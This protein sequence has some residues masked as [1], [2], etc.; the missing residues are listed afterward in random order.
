M[1]SARQGGVV[2]LLLSAA[3]GLLLV[4]GA[5]GG[6]V[7]PLVRGLSEDLEG[8]PAEDAAVLLVT[9]RPPDCFTV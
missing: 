6:E 5:G 8:A 9:V 1:I 3:M 4:V 7:G 2:H